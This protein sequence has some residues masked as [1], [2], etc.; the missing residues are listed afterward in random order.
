MCI[1][2]VEWPSNAAS[3]PKWSMQN[4]K[5]RLSQV[6]RA[7]A[8]ES[9]ALPKSDRGPMVDK[10]RRLIKEDVPNFPSKFGGGLGS[11]LT[12]G[13]FNDDKTDKGAATPME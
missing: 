13:F 9:I 2:R 1:Q 5:C 10:A 3:K 11:G 7:L 4:M 6:E 12:G 8:G